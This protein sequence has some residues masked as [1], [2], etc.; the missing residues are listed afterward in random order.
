MKIVTLGSGSKGNS[1]LVATDST[2]ILI[3]AGLPITEIEAK[4]ISLGV[5]PDEIEAILVTH[6]HSDHIKSIEKFCTKH[7]SKVYAHKN[8]MAILTQKLKGLNADFFVSFDED[9]YVGDMTISAFELSHDSAFCVGY[10]IFCGG[11]KFS[12]ATDLG[13]CPPKVIE[14][15]KGSD[16]VI[17]E[18]NHDEALLASNQKYPVVLKKRIM[19]SKGHLS[20]KASAEVISQLVGGTSQVILGHLSEENNS[21]SHAYSQ[22]KTFLAQKGII[23]GKNIFIDVATQHKLG[24]VFEI[25]SKN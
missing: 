21:P 16:V 8:E 24:N 9:F 5:N 25:K 6:E 13:Y 4:L 11:A 15:L 23:E 12:I 7:G 20:N 10:S 1:T 2:K 3:D 22:V 14:K 19:S 17:L 18:A